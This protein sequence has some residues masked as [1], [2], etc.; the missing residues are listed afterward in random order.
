MLP[1]YYLVKN[2]D[3]EKL[4]EMRLIKH[5]IDKIACF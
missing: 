1:F 4:G 3:A 2:C 5:E